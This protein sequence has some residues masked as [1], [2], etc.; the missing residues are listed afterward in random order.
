MVICYQKIAKRE[1]L[2][3]DIK[4]EAKRAAVISLF[5]PPATSVL[6]TFE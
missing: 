2:K 1:N 5:S 3:I 6:V 4:R